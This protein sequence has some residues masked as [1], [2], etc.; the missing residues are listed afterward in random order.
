MSAALYAPLQDSSKLNPAGQLKTPE[1][2][3]ESERQI[4]KDS[5]DKHL[6]M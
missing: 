2:V 6:R 1:R 3:S 5:S 4:H